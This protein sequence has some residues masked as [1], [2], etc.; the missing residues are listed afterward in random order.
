[1]CDR[2]S[3]R[4]QNTDDGNRSAVESLR[5]DAKMFRSFPFGV[6]LT[7]AFVLSSCAP[8]SAQATRLTSLGG[9][10][11]VS[12]QYE[13]LRIDE[14]GAVSLKGGHLLVRGSFE[15][16][17]IDLPPFV[18]TARVV[19]HWALTTES[20]SDDGKKVL[21]FTHDESLEDF[22]IALPAT[23][24]EV[25]YGVFTNKDGGDVMVLTWGR[26]ATC[27]WGYLTIGAS[28]KPPTPAR[29]E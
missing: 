8:A 1:M 26:D 10:V 20:N 16:V 24:A 3:P 27:F 11:A 15:T 19:R 25:R 7:S 14:V 18:D 21:T 12:G 17:T 5:Y 28:S 29:G 6:P 13:P 23:D 22:T 9:S 4:R 2:Q